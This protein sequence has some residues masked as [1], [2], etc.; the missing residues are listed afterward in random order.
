LHIDGSKSEK[1]DKKK[2]EESNRVK[3]FRTMPLP[4][5]QAVVFDLTIHLEEL[6][7]EIN[8]LSENNREIREHIM[9]LEKSIEEKG[10]RKK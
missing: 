7:R 3:Q 10:I 5:L 1:K 2:S 9:K 4:D 8:N 6:H